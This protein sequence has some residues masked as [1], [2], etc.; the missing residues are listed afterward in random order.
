HPVPGVDGEA[1]E[2]GTTLAELAA[3]KRGTAIVFG[4]ETTVTVSGG[5]KGGR[6][7]EL[8]VAAACA[9]EEA[10]I[11]G[12]SACIGTDGRD[13]PTD[14]AGAVIVVSDTTNW[15]V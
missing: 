3:S 15:R 7:Q 14:A 8:V 13:G 4:G 10:G 2:T 9:L 5:G 1:R 11:S 12:V 6:C